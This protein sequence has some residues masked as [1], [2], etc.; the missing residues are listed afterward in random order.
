MWILARKKTNQIMLAIAAS[1]LVGGA[2][3]LF[4]MKDN[5]QSMYVVALALGGM[6]LVW[7][8]SWLSNRA[9][10]KR[11]RRPGSEPSAAPS[12]RKRDA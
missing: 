7:L 2:L 10:L 11:R 8:L 12:G 5:G 1:I 6:A 4:Q 3:R 9:A